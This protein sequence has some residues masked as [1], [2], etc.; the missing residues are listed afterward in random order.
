M[1]WRKLGDNGQE[2]CCSLDYVLKSVQALKDA[3]QTGLRLDGEG[4][5]NVDLKQLWCRD[6]LW[7]ATD[8]PVIAEDAKTAL[9]QMKDAKKI[10]SLLSKSLDESIQA[11]TEATVGTC[12]ATGFAL[13]PDDVL[14]CIFEMYIDMI[15][16]SDYELCRRFREI[17]LRRSNLWRNISL[18]FPKH[19]LLAYEERCRHP[20]L[21]IEPAVSTF[22]TYEEML[23]VIQPHH[24]WR[25]LRLHVTNE[26]HLHRYFERLK[27]TIHGP[28]Q[29]LESL[30]ISNDFCGGGDSPSSEIDFAKPTF[31]FVENFALDTWRYL[32]TG[33]LFKRIFNS[34][35]NVQLVSLVLPHSSN[36]RI[37]DRSLDNE[38]FKRLRILHVMVPRM[39]SYKL[40]FDEGGFDAL[41]NDKRCRDFKKMEVRVGPLHSTEK[42]KARLQS[43]LGEKLHWIESS[44]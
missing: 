18:T 29:A 40:P 33:F 44:E 31:E 41:F 37:L 6:L 4:G 16:F 5:T 10:L 27:P 14:I 11:A 39:P 35:P 21:H 19:I 15:V 32:G 12:R 2:L 26:D 43:L 22:S 1:G 28:F 17:V 20:V 36:I 34:M 8:T 23:D 38:A 9:R 30:S 42:G 7:S 25:E 24:Q 3:I 13:L